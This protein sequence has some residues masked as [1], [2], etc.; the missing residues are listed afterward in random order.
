[1][2][3]RKHFFTI[4]LLTLSYFSYG[5]DKISFIKDVKLKN[6]IDN[7]FNAYSSYDSIKT[8]FYN[9]SLTYVI[10]YDNSQASKLLNGYD[11]KNKKYRLTFEGD[12]YLLK[13]EYPKVYDIISKKTFFKKIL[14]ICKG[15]NFWFDFSKKNYQIR[16][17]EGGDNYPYAR[18]IEKKFQEFSQLLNNNYNKSIIPTGDSVLIFQDIV[19][20]SGDLEGK[21]ELYCGN[22]DMFYDYFM[23]TIED[24]IPRGKPSY[25]ARRPIYY[26]FIKDWARKSV[27]D[28][29]VKLNANGTITVTTTGHGRTLRI[30]NYIDDPDSNLFL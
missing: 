12:Q 25:L 19:T 27:V 7:I 13:K 6:E 1:M 14:K 5:Q 3:I 4:L 11:T 29:F 30:K 22:K 20:A 8:I 17:L 2:K 15:D 28:I 18:P 26:P 10:L 23:K 24:F 16:Q 9:K 21:M